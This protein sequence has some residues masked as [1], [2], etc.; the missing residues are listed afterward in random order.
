MEP[1]ACP[2]PAQTLILPVNEDLAQENPAA[3]NLKAPYT[4]D[5]DTF[6]G[7]IGPKSEVTSLSAIKLSRSKKNKRSKRKRLTWSCS[8]GNGPCCCSSSF[9]ACPAYCSCS[10]AMSVEELRDKGSEGKNP[11]CR[12]GWQ[13]WRRIQGEAYDNGERN[14]LRGGLLCHFK[15]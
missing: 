8:T 5:S 6:W 3:E 12:T 4:K 10:I 14:G 15:I 2:T 9:C 13:T 7:W 11:P 1:I